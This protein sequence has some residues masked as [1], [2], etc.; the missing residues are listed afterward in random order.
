[1]KLKTK[2]I[3]EIGSN[4]NRDIKRCYKLIDEAKNLGFF[5]GNFNYLRLMN[6]FLKMQKTFIKMLLKK[7]ERTNFKF[8][9]ETS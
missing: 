4:H 3:A 6:Y 5:A 8:S 9:S 7:K 1:M 2:F